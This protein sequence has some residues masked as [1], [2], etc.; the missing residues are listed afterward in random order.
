VAP[1]AVASSSPVYRTTLVAFLRM[2]RTSYARKTAVDE[3]RG[4][5]TFDSAGM[6][7]YFVSKASPAAA[8]ALLSTTKT[9]SPTAQQ[10]AGFLT[11]RRGAVSGPWATITSAGLIRPGD[12]IA[13]TPAKGF[14]GAV[15]IA[16]GS[17]QLLSDGSY[18]LRVFDS[19]M[20][21]HGPRD[22][23]RSDNR[24][25]NRAGF[26]NGTVRLYTDKMGNLATIAWAMDRTGPK[27]SG[28]RVV[29]GRAR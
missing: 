2:T 22:T 24:A 7:N 15:L 13:V 5:Y 28:T 29:A 23:R 17:P 1:L 25:K 6:S 21:P 26:G 11:A 10:W 14:G 9:T 19:E 12:F 27:L 4:T 18:A 16:A 3:V 8:T 20:V